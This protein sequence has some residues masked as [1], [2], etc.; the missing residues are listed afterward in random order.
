LVA[1]G[2][3]ALVATSVSPV[4]ARSRDRFLNVATSPAAL[5]SSD[6]PRVPPPGFVPMAI[7]IDAVLPVTVLPKLSCTVAVTAG[8]MATVETALVGCWLNTRL[9]AAAEVMLNAALVAL[10]KPVLEA[11]SV[12]PVPVR[13]MDRL[14]NVATPPEALAVRVPPSV[15]PPGLVPMAIVIEAALVTVLPPA[16]WTVTWTG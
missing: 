9:L 11:P 8:L 6:L 1:A 13:L 2:R 10:V 16:S 4:P 5:R 3:P 14:P 15:P 12:Y 7:V